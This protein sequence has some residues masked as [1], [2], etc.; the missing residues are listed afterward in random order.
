MDT[1]L[2]RGQLEADIKLI[3]SS[4]K[5]TIRLKDIELG[6]S[7]ADQ[8]VEAEAGSTTP[9]SPSDES[10]AAIMFGDACRRLASF[11]SFKGNP[12][13]AKI[14]VR[15]A[16]GEIESFTELRQVEDYNQYYV[17]LD[18]EVQQALEEVEV[19]VLSLG[20]SLADSVGSESTSLD[21]FIALLVERSSE[22]DRTTLQ[23]MQK[24]Y[25]AGE[26]PAVGSAIVK[27]M[28]WAE[29]PTSTQD[30]GSP[31]NRDDQPDGPVSVGSWAHAG[32]IYLS[33]EKDKLTLK[34]WRFAKMLFEAMPNS[35]DI[36][37]FAEA[38]LEDQ[39]K[40]VNESMAKSWQSKSLAFFRKHDI[41]LTIEKSGSL[42]TM[43]QLES[44][45]KESS[46]KS[47]A[48]L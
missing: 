46:E 41:P 15:I 20:I 22:N 34:P 17:E 23:A 24:L 28:G 35:L 40:N 14:L 4:I 31:E 27:L 42:F 2:T 21:D 6:K 18:W 1:P 11:A 36:K 26:S 9:D 10:Q 48:N 33:K 38:L 25:E 37:S 16:A 45:E 43:R 32:V 19:E 13:A 47:E 39:A 29:P 8:M 7:V 44:C 30:E 5:E 3:Q 12:T